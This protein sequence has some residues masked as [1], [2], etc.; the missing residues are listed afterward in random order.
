MGE[1]KKTAD[2]AM[3]TDV[4]QRSLVPQE[5][6][7]QLLKKADLSISVAESCTGGLLCSRL[8]SV[9]GISKFFKEGFVTY[10]SKAKRKTLEVSKST[11]KKQGAVSG[12]TAKEMAIG[13]AMN[14]DTDVAVSVTGNAGPSAEEDKPV[15]LVYIGI[16][17]SGKVKAYE[18]M[19]EGER[20][21][22]RS[23]AAS[24]AISLCCRALEKYL[25]KN[26]E[27]E[28]PKEKPEKADKH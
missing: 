18:Y 19:F 4:V 17:L 9:P 8:V 5:E 25:S 14:A 21:D 22:I 27:K 26:S 12:Q 2:P 24:E 1:T 3:E 11:L 20:D 6:L 23:Q 28:R 13:A 7:Y 16:Y 10:S 15:G